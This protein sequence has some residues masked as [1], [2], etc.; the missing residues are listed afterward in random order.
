[1]KAKLYG[2]Y[3]F[4]KEE[5][6]PV[7]DYLRA[8]RE[9]RPVK[10]SEIAKHGLA[11]STIGK[12]FDGKTRSPRFATVMVIARA[13]GPEGVEAVAKCA[14]FGGRKMKVVEGGRKRNA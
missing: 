9:K 7:V 2:N 6:D 4:R 14:R 1:M 3:H 5:Q 12:L 10:T 8:A 11:S 13:I